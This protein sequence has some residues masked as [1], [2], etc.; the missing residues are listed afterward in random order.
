MSFLNH[1]SKHKM[2]FI[3]LLRFPKSINSQFAH[4]YHKRVNN[5]KWSSKSKV[6][7]G[8]NPDEE[9]SLYK[10]QNSRRVSTELQ[11]LAHD[12]FS[13]KWDRPARLKP[14]SEASDKYEIVFGVSPCLL[15]LTQARRKALKL[16]VKDGEPSHRSSLIRV[17]EEAHKRQV[18]I[19][20]VG[21]KDLDRM[22]SGR[23]HQGVCLEATPLSY[24]TEDSTPSLNSTPLWLV[25]DG[26]QDPMNLGA[27]L[28]SA[29]FL[30]VDRVASSVHNSCPL[31][32]VVSKASAGIMEVMGVYGYKDLE[33][34]VRVKA[35]QG[36]RVVGTVGAEAR[37][38]SVP[39]T[40][41]SNLRLTAPTLLLIG[42]EGDGLSQ[43]LLE[44]CQ[45]LVTI[46]PGRQLLLGVESLN[47]SVATGIL[48]H[49][50]LAS[51][52]PA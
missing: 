5:I 51:S 34:M 10:T 44:L 35:S 17:C 13:S 3:R 37:E 36:W 6:S 7:G 32:P 14:S 1:A 9:T 47:V 16:F 43:K 45:M 12:D 40:P 42:G 4:N 2:L 22:S 23:V 29:Y 28:R 50:L 41:C 30:G 46:P 33:N 49:S 52:R 18:P 27:V 20:R 15:A 26:I 19:Q 8:R 25:L 38:S 31:T 11:K 48:L 39:V 24:L 21:K